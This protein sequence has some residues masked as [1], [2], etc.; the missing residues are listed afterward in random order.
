MVVCQLLEANV[1]NAINC[2][3]SLLSPAMT[4]WCS[5][6][7]S[8]IQVCLPKNHSEVMLPSC[9]AGFSAGHL[10]IGLCKSL[11]IFNF[12]WCRWCCW[13]QWGSAWV[14]TGAANEELLFQV[15]TETNGWTYVWRRGCR[16]LIH[17]QNILPTFTSFSKFECSVNSWWPTCYSAFMAQYCWD[18]KGCV[19]ELYK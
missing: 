8:D 15:I 11:S 17:G 5:E 18:E 12:L 3:E 7:Q 9:T 10:K 13:R 16:D 1:L 2:M 19:D 6:V 14:C 4:G